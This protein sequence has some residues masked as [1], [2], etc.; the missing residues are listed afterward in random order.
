MLINYIKSIILIISI[1][2]Q[3]CGSRLAGQTCSLCS[4]VPMNSP[5][6]DVLVG[7]FSEMNMHPNRNLSFE[8]MC[9]IVQII[10]IIEKKTRLIEI[11]PHELG[12]CSSNESFPLDHMA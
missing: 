9:I 2:L 3:V 11:K 1:I 8:T 7:Q 12:T 5:V 6:V 4:L 10:E